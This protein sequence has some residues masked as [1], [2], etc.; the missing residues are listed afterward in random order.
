MLLL[1]SPPPLRTSAVIAQQPAAERAMAH[2]SLAGPSEQNAEPR[3]SDATPLA[4]KNGFAFSFFYSLSPWTS[5]HLL[6]LS[7]LDFSRKEKVCSRGSHERRVE[8]NTDKWKK[9]E[10]KRRK[11]KQALHPVMS[12][13]A[14]ALLFPSLCS[15]SPAPL[16]R[17]LL[18]LLWKGRA[19]RA[20]VA[21]MGAGRPQLQQ[22]ER[23]RR[24]RARESN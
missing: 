21:L 14:A 16:F 15:C 2:R 6:S 9:E 5:M 11:K 13:H 23:E 18:F 22:T 10:E 4:A 17:A 24:A 7:L 19:A 1:L 3:S 20:Q 12:P 8:S